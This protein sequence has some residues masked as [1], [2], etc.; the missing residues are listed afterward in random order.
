MQVQRLQS[1]WSIHILSLLTLTLNRDWPVRIMLKNFWS[2]CS[3]R[4]ESD[5]ETIVLSRRTLSAL[6]WLLNPTTL[7]L[8]RLNFLWHVFVLVTYLKSKAMLK[9]VLSLHTLVLGKYEV[10]QATVQ[11]HGFNKE[12]CPDLKSIGYLSASTAALPTHLVVKVKLRVT[13]TAIAFLRKQVDYLT[14][15]NTEFLH[16]VS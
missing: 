16:L 11:S 2:K 7:W 12:Y 4:Q 1:W 10:I 9:L 6:Y 14:A 13:A 5:W 8:P 15:A 3:G